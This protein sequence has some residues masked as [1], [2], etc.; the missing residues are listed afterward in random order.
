[1]SNTTEWR[2]VCRH[3]MC[4]KLIERGEC[5]GF[6]SMGCDVYF[7]FMTMGFCDTCIEECR[8]VRE[9]FGYE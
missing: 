9:E 7:E 5:P 3:I 8:K 1:M 4:E 2:T 6:E